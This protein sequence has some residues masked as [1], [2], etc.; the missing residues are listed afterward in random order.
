MTFDS[1]LSYRLHLRQVASRAKQ[2]LGLLRKT[3]P[4][5]SHAGRVTVYKGFGR[6]MM[7]YAP[8]PPLA[9]MGSVPSQLAMLDAVQLRALNVI[10]PGTI[11]PSLL[12][13]RKVS[14]LCLLYKLMC[15]HG[16][17][18]GA[19]MCPPPPSPPR[20]LYRH[21]IAAHEQPKHSTTPTCLS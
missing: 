14:A 21:V 5:L 12:V 1:K 6:P 3:A 18:Q 20:R 4:L 8:P 10:G 17:P 7:E 16:L 19:A 2:R 15:G 9:W 11:L 13:R